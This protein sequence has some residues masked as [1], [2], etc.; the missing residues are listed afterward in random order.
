MIVCQGYQ[1]APIQPRLLCPN[2]LQQVHN[3][4]A[5]PLQQ[6]DSPPPA[7]VRL[8]SS[9]QYSSIRVSVRSVR[10]HTNTSSVSGSEI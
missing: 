1:N 4:Q 6:C 10:F 7:P 9:D 8:F 5:N 2:R 3:L